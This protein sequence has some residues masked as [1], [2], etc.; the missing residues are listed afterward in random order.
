MSN[1]GWPSTLP[2][3]PF[4][5]GPDQ[6][7]QSNSIRT[8]VDAGPPKARRRYT[9]VFTPVTFNLIL[10]E[11]EITILNTF[12][13]TTLQDVLPFDWVDFQNTGNVATYRFLSR[14][15][16]KWYADNLWTVGFNL[17]KLP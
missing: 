11:A 5:D 16:T 13:I 1:P 9:A 3:N 17:E 7:P 6:Q 4:Q 15:T 10:S 14:P 12:V 2:Q 8:G